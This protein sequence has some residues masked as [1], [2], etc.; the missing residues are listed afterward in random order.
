MTSP[1][2]VL[3]SWALLYWFSFHDCVASSFVSECDGQV[4]IDPRV[5][6]V[7]S[8]S[9]GH[10]CVEDAR[11]ELWIQ[12]TPLI[13]CWLDILT[14]SSFFAILICGVLWPH[15]VIPWSRLNPCAC[16]GS[17]HYA[18]WHGVQRWLD[19]QGN[20]VCEIYQ[21]PYKDG[22]NT[23]EYFRMLDEEHW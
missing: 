15:F 4:W 8:F 12:E 11:W 10:Q 6:H 23:W 9:L 21:Q 18:H 16:T 22:Y 19:S 1:S 20:K 5:V 7:L 3:F 14:I 17:I 13:L 2:W